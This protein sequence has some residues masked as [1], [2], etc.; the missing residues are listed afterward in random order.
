MAHGIIYYIH[1]CSAMHGAN[2]KWI[3]YSYGTVQRQLYKS[4]LRTCKIPLSD[5]RR[6]PRLEHARFH[7]VIYAGCS[8]RVLGNAWSR[9]P[10]VGTSTQWSLWYIL[11]VIQIQYVPPRHN[12]FT[13]TTYSLVLLYMTLYDLVCMYNNLYTSPVVLVRDSSQDGYK[14]NIIM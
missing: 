14:R 10:H 3:E 1:V 7:S 8:R 9:A 11:T 2:W 12:S 4:T 13:H 6:V 5:I